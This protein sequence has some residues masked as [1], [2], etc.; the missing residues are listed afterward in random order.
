MDVTPT[1]TQTASQGGAKAQTARQGTLINS[2]FQTFLVMLTTQMQNQDPLNP[3]ESS[4][5]AAQLATFSGVEQQVKTNTLLE[6]LASQMGL[7]G[8][9]QMASWVGMEARVSA[10]VM[11]DGAPLTLYPAPAEGADEAVLVVLNASGQ[12]VARQQIALSDDPVTWAGTDASGT[13]L[14]S[15]SYAFRLENYTAGE[16]AG[17]TAVDAY[18]RIDEVR[19]GTDG[20]VLVLQGGAMVAPADIR[21]LR[22]PAAG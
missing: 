11:F 18:G 14:A 19:N 5:Y 17:I 9:A 1:T 2:D 10:P 7:S 8:M 15:G 20:A 22:S 3:I 21:A 4:D 12:E 6:S 13:P 16:L